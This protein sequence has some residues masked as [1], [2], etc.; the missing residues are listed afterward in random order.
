MLLLLLALLNAIC[1]G[2]C[3]YDVI[4]SIKELSVRN[5]ISW[6][7]IT[8]QASA[9]NKKEGSVILLQANKHIKHVLT[10]KLNNAFWQRESKALGDF[11]I[12]SRFKSHID[13][14]RLLREKRN[15][16]SSQTD[17]VNTDLAT[18]IEE[19]K[20]FMQ[21]NT[22][23]RPLNKRDRKRK[24]GYPKVVLPIQKLFADVGVSFQKYLSPDIFHDS[25]D[26]NANSLNIE[27]L[28]ADGK[29]LFATSWIKFDQSNLK[30]F[31]FPL[32]GNQHE[33]SFALKATN[34]KGK[35]AIQSITIV[36]HSLEPS[37]NHYIHLCTTMTLSEYGGS[38][39]RRLRLAKAIANYIFPG[40]R[41]ENLWIWKF[42]KGCMY[43]SFRHL[44]RKGRCDFDAL[45][46]IEEKI[47]DNGEVNSAFQQAL[48][49]ITGV[50][51]VNLTV[52]YECRRS[53]STIVDNELGWLRDIAPIFILLAVVAVPTLISCI[54]CREVRRRQAAMRQLQDRR[55][56]E[57]REQMLIQAA[58]YKHECGLDSESED[59]EECTNRPYRQLEEES[60]K[61]FG[62][63]RIADIILPE[64]VLDTMKQGT[65]ILSTF[66]PQETRESAVSD[67]KIGPA[68]RFTTDTISHSLN[69]INLTSQEE[70]G[71]LIE[72]PE[73][74][75][76]SKVKG[77][78]NFIKSPL[79][80]TPFDYNLDSEENSRGVQIKTVEGRKLSNI[81]AETLLPSISSLF[82]LN[83]TDVTQGSLREVKERMTTSIRHKLQLMVNATTINRSKENSGEQA[84]EKMNSI[85]APGFSDTT[86]Q[87]S[88]ASLRRIAAPFTYAD[89]PTSASVPRPM[90]T[91]VET[92][93]QRTLLEG[94]VVKNNTE[95]E[96][97]EGD[98]KN[99][100]LLNRMLYQSK[101]LV[102]SARKWSASSKDS[103]D[104]MQL[105]KVTKGNWEYDVD[106]KRRLSIAYNSATSC[107]AENSKN[108]MFSSIYDD[109][110]NPFSKY[111]ST[112]ETR[113]AENRRT[114]LTHESNEVSGFLQAVIRNQEL[115]ESA[116]RYFVNI[117]EEQV[118]K[119]SSLIEVADA[120]CRQVES[121]NRRREPDGKQTLDK[122]QPSI[123]TR[124]NLEKESCFRYSGKE[125]ENTLRGLKHYDP[126]SGTW[127]SA[128]NSL[129]EGTP[130]EKMSS[131]LKSFK[132]NEEGNLSESSLLKSENVYRSSLHWHKINREPERQLQMDR[133]IYTS[134]IEVGAVLDQNSSNLYEQNIESASNDESNL[135]GCIERREEPKGIWTDNIYD[136]Y[137][138]DSDPCQTSDEE[139]D[140][141][142][143]IKKMQ[144]E[145]LHHRYV[146]SEMY[147]SNSYLD[148]SMQ[149]DG[150]GHDQAGHLE[151]ASADP[152]SKSIGHDCIAITNPYH[153]H[154]MC[155]EAE[156]CP[157]Q[158]SRKHL[159]ET[160]FSHQVN[161]DRE[162]I[163]IVNK[164]ILTEKGSKCDSFEAAEDYPEEVIRGRGRSLTDG[165][166]QLSMTYLRAVE[167]P[168]RSEPGY[169]AKIKDGIKTRKERRSFL[170]RQRRV[171]IPEKSNASNDQPD[172]PT[173]HVNPI[174]VSEERKIKDGIEERKLVEDRFDF[175]TIKR[176]QS[177]NEVTSQSSSRMRKHAYSGPF[178]TA[179]YE[180]EKFRKQDADIIEHQTKGYFERRRQNMQHL[181]DKNQP[182]KPSLEELEPFGM[183]NRARREDAQRRAGIRRFSTPSMESWTS[184]PE[185]YYYDATGDHSISEDDVNC[186]G[187]K[188]GNEK[189]PVA[190]GKG[191]A[192]EYTQRLL[193]GVS[194][195]IRRHSTSILGQRCGRNQSGN[196]LT[197]TGTFLGRI[198]EGKLVQ[199]IQTKLGK[200]DSRAEESKSPITKEKERNIEEEKQLKGSTLTAIRNTLL[201]LSGGK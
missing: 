97:I 166:L 84:D 82:G 33:H 85:K 81:P 1:L 126:V 112:A 191:R 90:R 104:S 67:D 80:I 151:S 51:S 59:D 174:F 77:V 187:L 2:H 66:L 154:F 106:Y 6:S 170:E 165:Q 110:G 100:G 188:K 195:K 143:L 20:S 133:N 183:S 161:S 26:G 172:V 94:K 46:T 95:E 78:L 75:F 5:K 186:I 136:D 91:R 144:D 113:S 164:E 123:N 31:G 49:G 47:L 200:K 102:N 87:S 30:L 61:F 148:E 39:E 127:Y 182:G 197:S 130:I 32:K 96:V 109:Y 14:V 189:S 120:S 199:T 92:P 40:V 38:V 15:I 173:I 19:P 60:K 108:Q 116:D 159:D 10:Q 177:I 107:E 158:Q 152:V 24:P 192:K 68:R 198:G 125:D 145:R 36:V 147:L 117:G 201:L 193:Q 25:K 140:F 9:Q 118:G 4:A 103:Q 64:V 16:G 99:I 43:L 28:T 135:V 150:Y 128:H 138:E 73:S 53:N 88:K 56:K 181:A 41:T 124:L 105:K 146:P 168:T 79:D 37:L 93:G 155:S 190:S 55:M 72:K 17:L 89:F 119:E 23:L 86:I 50:I 76:A 141:Q 18:Q 179:N 71:H 21:N 101:N 194:P 57:D 156:E 137:M 35:S 175:A 98:V 157:N 134:D 180:A 132:R 142:V 176:M 27:L 196:T 11:R 83:T 42:Q 8:F 139:A 129:K 162:I 12:K 131:F 160:D 171:E 185:K 167:S 178:L 54:V 69:K 3:T 58:E 70:I 121:H 52:Q 63:S 34:S 115:L 62:F 163:P 7:K 184:T 122:F 44:P 45:Q 149:S 114:D 22:I 74:S 29:K 48:K 169:T 153:L 65:E 111:N 13:L